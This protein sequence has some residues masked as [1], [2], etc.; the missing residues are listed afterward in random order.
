[1]TA[2]R[3][4]VYVALLSMICFAILL[5][6]GLFDGQKSVGVAR[7]T[8]C[9][10]HQ[11]S[12]YDAIERYKTD[13]GSLPLTLQALVKDGY[14]DK[15]SIRCPLDLKQDPERV[16]DYFPE[17]FGR[18]ESILL[19]DAHEGHSSSYVYKGHPFHVATFGNGRIVYIITVGPKQ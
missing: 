8:V 16:Y 18:D 19:L 17:N 1:M 7:L 6:S 2:K 13:T 5:V 15:K 11:R 4:V 12:I 3:V 9:R 14:V 10:V